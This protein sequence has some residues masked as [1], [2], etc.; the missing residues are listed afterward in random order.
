[1]CVFACERAGVSMK[2]IR[3][4]QMEMKKS[5]VEANYIKGKKFE[6]QVGTITF[7][8]FFY[9]RRRGAKMKNG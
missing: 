4:L 5:H 6:N 7:D 3:K 8:N 9:R 2:E 1:M